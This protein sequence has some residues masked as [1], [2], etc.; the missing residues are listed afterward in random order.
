M[1]QCCR[2][3]Q[4]IIRAC[5]FQFRQAGRYFVKAAAAAKDAKDDSVI[6]ASDSYRRCGDFRNATDVLYKN[7]QYLECIKVIKEYEME[8]QVPTLRLQPPRSTLRIE[9][10]V[11]EAA[12]ACVKRKDMSLLKEYM[13]ELTIDNQ[14]EYLSRKPGCEEIALE[15]LI[16]NG[17]A[18]EAAEIHMR[19][20]RYL[21]AASCTMKKVTKGICYLE[22]ARLIY[23]KGSN[24]I[25][26]SL[27]QVID[28]ALQ[29]LN[30]AVPCLPDDAENLADCYFM[31]GVL[32]DKLQFIKYAAELFGKSGNHVGLLLCN[33]KL[34]SKGEITSNIVVESLNKMLLLVG[35]RSTKRMKMLQNYFGIEKV[36]INDAELYFRINRPKLQLHLDWLVCSKGHIEVLLKHFDGNEEG[37]GN[38]RIFSANFNIANLV[39]QTLMTLYDKELQTSEICFQHLQGIPHEECGLE[40]KCP[41]LKTIQN[42]CT[43][44]C[45]ILQMHGLLRERMT[46]ILKTSKLKEHANRF[47]YLTCYTDDKMIETCHSFYQ[48]LMCF[49]QFLSRTQCTGMH[50]V[51]SL[52]EVSFVKDQIH[53]C[54]KSIWQ[55]AGDKGRFSDMNVFLEVF[56]L[57]SYAGTRFVQYAVD[58]IHKEIETRYGSEKRLTRNEIALFNTREERYETFHTMFMDSKLWMHDDGALIECLHVLLRRGLTLVVRRDV[59]PPSLTNSVTLLEFSLSLCL[60]SLSRT[61]RKFVIYLPEFYTE[62]VQFWSGCYTSCFNAKYSAFDNIDY[63][64]KGNKV[65]KSLV[66]VILD[67]LSG[68]KSDRFDLIDLAFGDTDLLV[69]DLRHRADAERFLVLVLVILGNHRIFSDDSASVRPIVLKL[70]EHARKDRKVPGF[71]PGALDS[72]SRFQSRDD[73][74]TAL[75]KILQQSGR[76]V[77]AWTWKTIRSYYLQREAN[78]EKP[79]T[80]QRPT[81]EEKGPVINDKQPTVILRPDDSNLVQKKNEDKGD[82]L[83]LKQ[84]TSAYTKA[85]DEND[86]YTKA[87]DEKGQVINDKQPTV[88]LRPDDSNLVQK[89]NEDKGDGLSLKQNTSAYTK[90][91]DENDSYTKAEDEKGQV[92]NDKQPTVILRPD[93]SNLVQ[94]KNEDKGDGLSLKQ[95]TS[96]YTK[97]EDEN[98]SLQDVKG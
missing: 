64:T 32:T 63:V 76:A 56:T 44:Y 92:I 29:Y 48:D 43:A 51:R 11:K 23:S 17:R 30:M 85:E 91:E 60:I 50:L 20:G 57:S 6:K 62:A 42:R 37:E 70:I 3:I 27:Q 22:Q 2:V 46:E 52:P 13:S 90:A 74:I 40:H 47:E 16:D 19:K 82:G 14:L 79:R 77:S 69:R 35:R 31:I 96:A 49:T 75:K 12:D 73:A 87:E 8:K 33:K 95:S 68:K 59:P 78:E 66:I 36:P 15:I 4:I 5:L 21:K 81:R 61:N 88:I 18:E 9:N 67:L 84:N 58:S 25:E 34:W 38:A 71:I 86:S 24:D 97:A 41:N 7:K 98:D 55:K 54:I 94:K 72:A 1:L 28:S 39:V 83:S 45:A 89:K 65:I 53:W 93:D 10:I 26:S 80:V